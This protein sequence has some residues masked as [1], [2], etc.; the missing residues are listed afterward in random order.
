[1]QLLSERCELDV[2]MLSA[3]IVNS[4]P[5]LIFMWYSESGGDGRLMQQIYCRVARH[6]L[7]VEEL[8]L[9]GTTCFD[10]I[11]FG[12]YAWEIRNKI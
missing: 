10:V 4:S 5:P 9:S 6:N 8:R 11:S 7:A 2:N 12:E 1:M 3:S